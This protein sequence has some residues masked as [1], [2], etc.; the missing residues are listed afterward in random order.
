MGGTF[1][2]DGKVVHID[3][4]GRQAMM[5]TTIRADHVNLVRTYDG[6]ALT[7]ASLIWR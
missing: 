1:D 2:A 6:S 5:N 4:T 7:H 3:P